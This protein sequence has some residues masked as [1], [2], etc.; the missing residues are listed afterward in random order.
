MHSQRQRQRQLDKYSS[1]IA[2]YARAAPPVVPAES[3]L[4]VVDM[5]EYFASI[6]EPITETVNWAIAACRAKGV[7]VFFTQHGH[8]EPQ[9]DG[10]MLGE[11]WGDLIVEGTAEHRLVSDL[12]VAADD[13]VVAK[14]RYDAFFG[15]ALERV[16]HERGIRDLCVAGVMTNLCVETTA[17]AAFVRDYRVRVLLDGTATASEELQIAALRNLAFGFAHVQTAADWLA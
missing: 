2:P 7:G 15:T 12:H 8:A 1:A 16:L 10:G 14:R 3:V 5:Q 6:C 17:R 9:R 4:L 13:L 11:W